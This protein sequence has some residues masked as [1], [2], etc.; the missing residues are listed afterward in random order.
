MGGSSCSRCF[1]VSHVHL[2]H[3]HAR[4]PKLTQ[5]P[6]W[7][8]ATMVPPNNSIR[9]PAVITTER[10]KAALQKKTTANR[11]KDNVAFGLHDE[12]SVVR[13]ATVVARYPT[14]TIPRE[15]QATTVVANAATTDATTTDP[16]CF[17]EVPLW[18]SAPFIAV[19]ST[20]SICP[21]AEGNYE[22]DQQL[23]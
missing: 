7:P 18:E 23:D 9:E 16:C 4:A 6:P 20:A 8:H 17:T 13:P 12:A 14:H 15:Q 1:E 21:A 11:K 10:F 5:P 22:Q 19:L 3:R 2:P